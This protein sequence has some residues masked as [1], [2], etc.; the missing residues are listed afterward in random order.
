MTL[1]RALNEHEWER[2]VPTVKAL[3]GYRYHQGRRRN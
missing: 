2:W 1:Y 3:G